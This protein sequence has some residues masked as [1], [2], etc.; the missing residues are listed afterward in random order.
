MEDGPA[1]WARAILRQLQLHESCE[2]A[3]SVLPWFQ[4]GAWAS[5]PVLTPLHDGQWPSGTSGKK[6]SSS[7]VIPSLDP[8]LITATGRKIE[9]ELRA[10]TVA[11]LS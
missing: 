9:Q 3:G 1:P 2:P 6:A 5:V 10:M 4:L 11:A 8:C 7:H